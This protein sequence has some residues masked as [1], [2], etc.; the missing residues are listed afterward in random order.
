M[1]KKVVNAPDC[2]STGGRYAQAV[3]A[4][5]VSDLLVLSGQ[6]PIDAEGTAPDGALAQSDQVWRNID[7]QLRE[8]C[9]AKEDIIK[10][11]TYLARREDIEDCRASRLAYLD[12]VEAASTLIIAGI[13]DESWL[14][15]IEVMAAR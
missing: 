13:V 11:T 2:P 9:F 14:M 12:G 3:A 7:A 4:A 10:V 5:G 15:E 8:A 6:V 1:K